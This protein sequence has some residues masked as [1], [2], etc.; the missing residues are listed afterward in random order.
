MVR[1]HSTLELVEYDETTRAPEL[2]KHDRTVRAPERDSDT[3]ASELD[4]SQF[5][6]EVSGSA[7]RVFRPD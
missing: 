2:V 1:K 5:A 4:S 3:T 7:Y 6:P